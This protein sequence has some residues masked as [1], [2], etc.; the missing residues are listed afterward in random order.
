MTHAMLY[1]II[2]EAERWEDKV[3]PFREDLS[4]TQKAW[5]LGFA[6]AMQRVEIYGQALINEQK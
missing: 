3:T 4:D 6:A 5:R 1:Q 2:A